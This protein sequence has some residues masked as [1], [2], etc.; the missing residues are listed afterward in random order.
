MTT[1]QTSLASKSLRFRILLA[2]AA[3]LTCEI[4]PIAAV[5]EPI[6]I[7]VDRDNPKSDISL[8]ELRSL[9]LGERKNWPDGSR[10]V[11]VDVDWDSARVTFSRA[12]LQMNKNEVDTWW[13]DQQVRGHDMAPRVVSSP[14][15]AVKLVARMRGAVSYVP[16]SRVDSSIKVLTVDGKAPGEPGYPMN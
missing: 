13:V 5:A 2:L 3:S 15:L 10:A 4:A 1:G 9:F 7:V 14:R 16:R 11:P 6:A 8:E 12:A